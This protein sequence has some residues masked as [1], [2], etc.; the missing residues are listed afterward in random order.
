MDR[1]QSPEF[2]LTDR[3]AFLDSASAHPWQSFRAFSSK[4]GTQPHCP[5]PSQ[6]PEAAAPMTPHPL[7]NFANL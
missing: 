7:S 2:S 1:S 5:S 4:G 3:E 6:V